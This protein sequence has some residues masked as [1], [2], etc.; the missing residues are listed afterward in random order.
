MK[1]TIHVVETASGPVKIEAVFNL[2]GRELTDGERLAFVLFREAI[3]TVGE[4]M[5]KIAHGRAIVVSDGR[6]KT[7]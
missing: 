2:E 6:P 5:A 3:K 4:E 7:N 1:I